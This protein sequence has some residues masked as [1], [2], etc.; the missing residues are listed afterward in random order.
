MEIDDHFEIVLLCPGNPFFKVR[1][2]SLN[3]WVACIVQ[4]PVSNRDANVI[5]PAEREK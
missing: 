1:H 5:E 2:L 4:G 3:V